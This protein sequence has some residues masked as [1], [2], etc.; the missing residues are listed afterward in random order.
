MLKIKEAIIV[1]GKYDKMRLSALFDTLIIETGGFRIFKGPEKRRLINEIAEKRGI[2]ILTD[3]DAAGFVIRNHIK[4]IT[5]PQNVKHA[6][7]PQK[8]G[9]EKRKSSP[10]KEGLL[11]VEGISDDIIINAVLSSGA[12]VCDNAEPIHNNDHITKMFFYELGLAGKPDS[13]ERRKILLKHLDLPTYMSSNAMVEA[14][15]ILYTKNDLIDI[16]NRLFY[17]N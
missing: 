9:K 15:D 17:K 4:G 12:T 7:I 14:L 5:K 11:G 8:K 16:Y 13:A 10:S 3:S 2:I 1:E 6:F